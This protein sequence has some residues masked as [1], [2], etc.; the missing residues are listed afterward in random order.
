[1]FQEHVIHA[2]LVLEV[3]IIA[4]VRKVII[5]DVKELSSLTLIGIA[6]IIAALA[7]AYYL[8]KHTLYVGWSRKT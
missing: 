8:L 3:A 5:L 1:Y 4:I 2:E 7:G 6:A